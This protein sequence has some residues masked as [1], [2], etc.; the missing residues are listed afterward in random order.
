[1]GVASSEGDAK[2]HEQVRGRTVAGLR[3]PIFSARLHAAFRRGWSRHLTPEWC[4]A[5]VSVASRGSDARMH[6]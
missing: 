2:L 1:M 6:E 4:L 3:T 5:R